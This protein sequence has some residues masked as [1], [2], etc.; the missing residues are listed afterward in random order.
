MSPIKSYL[1]LVKFSHTIF[2]LPFAAIGFIIGIHSNPEIPINY[3]LW[4]WVLLCMITARNAAM[5]FNR[6]AD[7]DIDALNPR[8]QS[9][10][11]PAGLI[12]AKNALLFVALNA[13][14]FII[15]AYQINLV[16]FIL[17]PLALIIVLGYSYTKRYFWLCH[18]FLGLGLALAPLGAFLA[19]RGSFELLPTLYAIAVVAW[20]AG[21]DIIY[22]LQD[23][24]FDQS[25]QLKSIPAQFGIQ[26]ALWIS[27]GLHFI[28]AIC[29]FYATWLLHRDYGLND[30]IYIGST[31]F[32]MLLISQH[33]IIGKGDLS[34]VNL[35]FFST[36]GMASICLAAG[37]I[38]DFYF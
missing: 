30:G 26:T 34:K 27:S 35:A 2:A 17:S 23:V 4:I 19:V 29:I 15:S 16:C 13:L 10:E 32:V 22:A 3:N 7:R 20:V 14:V 25:H 21:F 38:F 36:N 24:E 5:A 6:W 11:I 28:C 31:A 12:S 37:I 33:I 8:T 1:S 18:L 9:R